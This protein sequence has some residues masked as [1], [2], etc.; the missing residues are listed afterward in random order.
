MPVEFRF[1]L[2]YLQDCAHSMTLVGRLVVCLV[3]REAS[4]TQKKELKRKVKFYAAAK[5]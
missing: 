2:V 4:I 3:T 1:N 5:Q